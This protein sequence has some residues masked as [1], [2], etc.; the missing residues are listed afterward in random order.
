MKVFIIRRGKVQPYTPCV[1]ST[2]FQC[3]MLAR[4]IQTGSVPFAVSAYLQRI[5][6]QMF[7]SDTYLCYSELDLEIGDTQ[8]RRCQN[9][10]VIARFTL[11]FCQ[12]GAGASV[13]LWRSAETCSDNPVSLSS[14]SVPRCYALHSNLPDL[15]NSL[16]LHH[17][18]I[19]GSSA[20]PF[21]RYF[22][23]KAD[24]LGWLIWLWGQSLIFQQLFKYFTKLSIWDTQLSL[25]THL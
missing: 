11:V 10:L 5:D 19:M 20:A 14:S 9:W 8:P 21:L 17:F 18:I 7:G 4:L 16:P 6:I 2:P 24:W 23:F 13:W 1:S 12:T 25:C 15:W 3:K 22:C